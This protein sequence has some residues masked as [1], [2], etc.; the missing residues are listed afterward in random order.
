MSKEKVKKLTFTPIFIE[1]IV[2]AI[3]DYPMI[4]IVVDGDNI[5]RKKFINIGMATALPSGNLIVPVIKNADSLN[6]VGLSK[7]VNGLANKAR[8]NKLSPDDITGGTLHD[9]QCRFF[10]QHNGYS[11]YQSTSGSNNGCRCNN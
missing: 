4:N 3:K 2:K 10:W 5:V 11:Y 8:T 1:A 7:S 9:Q 6:L